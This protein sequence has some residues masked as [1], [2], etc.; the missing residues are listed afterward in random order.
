MAGETGWRHLDRRYLH[1]FGD[2]VPVMERV[3]FRGR[4]AVLPCSQIYSTQKTL[5][6]LAPPVPGRASWASWPRLCRSW[7]ASACWRWRKWAWILALVSIA[8]TIVEGLVGMFS[9]GLFVL[10]CGVFGLM[11]PIAMLIYLL[12]RE[13]RRVFGM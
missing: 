9:N 13:T 12:R 1:R 10:L 7:L 8:V 2:S 5:R 3:G 6:L 11:I 4:R